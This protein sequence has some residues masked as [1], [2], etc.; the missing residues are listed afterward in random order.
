M[1]GM[2][3]SIVACM[4]ALEDENWRLKRRAEPGVPVPQMGSVRRFPAGRDCLIAA[5]M[6]EDLQVFAGA[7]KPPCL[8]TE[9]L[10]RTPG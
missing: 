8:Q 6:M 10:H 1:G 5:G 2:E 3:V 9:L 7:T 4:K